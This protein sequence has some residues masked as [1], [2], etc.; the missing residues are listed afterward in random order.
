MLRVVESGNAANCWAVESM[1]KMRVVIY[2][3]EEQR[4]GLEWHKRTSISE[5]GRRA[6]KEYLKRQVGYQSRRYNP[7]NPPGRKLYWMKQK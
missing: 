1:E 4:K 6:I 2:L 3:D 7:D 5:V